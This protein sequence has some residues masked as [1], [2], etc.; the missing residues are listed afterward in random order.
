M[1]KRYYSTDQE[2]QEEQLYVFLHTQDVLPIIHTRFQRIE[3]ASIPIAD[4]LM[5]SISSG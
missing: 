4:R 2:I 5:K 3:A 1:E